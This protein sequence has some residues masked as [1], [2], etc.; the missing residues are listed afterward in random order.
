[1]EKASALNVTSRSDAAATSSSRSTSSASPLLSIWTIFVVC[2]SCGLA[3]GV[4]VTR[5]GNI[6]S[7][8]SPPDVTKVISTACTSRTSPLTMLA[9]AGFSILPFTG[10][11]DIFVF[12][13]KA[14][15]GA[16]A[17]TL[18][19]PTVSTQLC[20]GISTSSNS[21]PRSVPVLSSSFGFSLLYSSEI[22]VL[23]WSSSASS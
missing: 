22:T 18:I 6:G 13:G 2:S 1:M 17:E 16:S 12:A 7:T 15:S 9:T 14:C 4:I 11:A 10:A 5:I 3:H 20:A 19:P 8:T 23:S 21:D